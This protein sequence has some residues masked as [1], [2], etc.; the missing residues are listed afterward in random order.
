MDDVRAQVLFFGVWGN[1]GEHSLGGHWMWLPTGNHLPH[2]ME[3]YLPQPLQ[4]PDGKYCRGR[5]PKDPYKITLPQEEGV[6]RINFVDG[7]TI[8]SFWDRSGAD[9]RGGCN[10]N[11]LLYGRHP[12]AEMRGV[13]FT[14]FPRIAARW[15]FPLVIEGPDIGPSP[16]CIFCEATKA[17][18]PKP[19]DWLVNGQSCCGYHL[20]G[21][22][23]RDGKENVVVA[24]K[25]A[26][27][28]PEAPP[29]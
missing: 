27:P 19:A 9:L 20:H 12:F 4:S 24:V 21:Y 26:I 28:A 13:A 3:R 6:C 10:S 15:T 29:P 23:R 18:D 2:E 16:F 25:A 1:R 7:W 5:D 11:F 8:L 17:P 22:L 14:R